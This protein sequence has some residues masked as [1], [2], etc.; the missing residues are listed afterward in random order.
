MKSIR[1]HTRAKRHGA[2][3]TMELVLVLPVFMLLLF[4]IVEFSLL[5]SARNRMTE[6]ARTGVRELCITNKSP[7]Y[8]RE[9][10][11]QRLGPKLSREIQVDITCPTDAGELANV[12]IAIP[13]KNATPD[14]LWLTGFSVKQRTLIVDAPM[15]R[16]HDLV[17]AYNEQAKN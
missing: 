13:M 15:I 3:L 10:V 12:R 14:L 8:I 5:S 1:Q 4:A 11:K 9:T 6:A 7:E 16:E 17:I 2:I